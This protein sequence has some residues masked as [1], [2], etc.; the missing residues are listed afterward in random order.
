LPHSRISAIPRAGAA[1]L[2]LLAPGAAL[3]SQ[4]ARAGD[5]VVS[6]MSW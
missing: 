6:V 2:A 3:V 5:D 1:A 4:P